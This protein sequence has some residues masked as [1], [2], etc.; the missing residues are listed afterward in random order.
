MRAGL[1][2]CDHVRPEFL[3]AFGDY[4]QQFTQLFSTWDWQFYDVTQGQFPTDIAECDVYLT[5]GS[6]HSVYEEL[7][8]IAQ[9]KSFIQTLYRADKYFIGVCFG[10]QLLAEA[11][12]GE[13][14]KSS[15]GWCVGVH[16][17]EVVQ[18][19]KWMMPEQNRFN[20]LMSCQDQ[21]LVL[22]EGAV[23]LACSEKCAVGMY[24]VGERMLGMQAHPEFSKAYA[25]ALMEQRVA[26]IGEQVVREGKASLELSVHAELIRSW[27]ELFS[28]Q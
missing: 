5:T 13:V 26:R 18:P 7:P 23:V 12:G 3:A 15:V 4:D 28:R 10:H 9:L 20:L 19:E 1:L 8:W 14:G 25:E 21:V 6:H 22:P 2:I 11:L 17:F 27:V 16:E 24:R